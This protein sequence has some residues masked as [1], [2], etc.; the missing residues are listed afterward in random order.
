M[1]YWKIVEFDK[2][3]NQRQAELPDIIKYQYIFYS[4]FFTWQANRNSN[5]DTDA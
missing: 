3:D 5:L 1:C 4:Q 2:V